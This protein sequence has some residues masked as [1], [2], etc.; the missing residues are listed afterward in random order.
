MRP[1]VSRLATN[2]K[3]VGALAKPACAPQRHL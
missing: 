2:D 3:R 1:I